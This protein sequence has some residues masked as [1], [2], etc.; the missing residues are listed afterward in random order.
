LNSLGVN[1]S[2]AIGPALAG[3]ILSFAGPAV[4]FLINALSVLGVV[5]VLYFWKAAPRIQRLPPEHFYPAVRAGLRYVQSAPVLR[6][7]LIRAV[8]FFTFGSAAWSLLPL[9]ARNRL[10]LNA[11]G[12]GLLLACIGVGAIA[13]AL[14]LPRLRKIFSIDWLALAATVVFAINT[15]ALALLTDALVV[16]IS[17][18]FAGFSWITML[19]ILNVGAQRSSAGWVKARALAVYLVVFFGAMAAGSAIWGQTAAHLGISNALM[20]AGIGMM[21]SC[22]TALR[23][24]L[25]LSPELDLTPSAHL[26]RPEIQDEPAHDSGP[27]M[28]TIE[29]RV[30]E[31]NA[32]SFRIA[33]REMRRVRLRGGALSWGI[34]EDAHVR[35]RYIETFVV[36]SWLEHLRQHDR[37]TENDRQIV[38][39]VHDFHTGP[40]APR[41]EHMIAPA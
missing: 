20:I 10:H 35:G 31:E 28:I 9:I 5:G 12:Y 1:I 37:F 29:Y 13:G 17:L 41:V 36:E 39:K 30:E 32:A 2:R 27:V 38:M 8:A 26:G 15:L 40:T 16:G 22:A 18:L 3:V 34:F 7:V 23:W 4:V 14:L 25:N 11:G 24:R 33:V 21:L 19:S 6:V